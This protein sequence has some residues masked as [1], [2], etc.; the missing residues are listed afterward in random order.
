MSS[1]INYTNSLIKL[2]QLMQYIEYKL[3]SPE[4]IAQQIELRNIEEKRRKVDKILKIVTK[5]I[6][7][8]NGI[9]YGGFALNTILPDELKFYDENE[10]PDFDFFQLDADNLSKVLADKLVKKGFKYTEV[11]HALHEGTYKVFSN[12]ESV[13]DITSVTK[14]EYDVLMGKAIRKSVGYSKKMLIAPLEFLKGAAYLELCLPIGSSFRWTK[15]YKR[16]LLLEQAYPLKQDSDM[17]SMD[18]LLKS[19]GISNQFKSIHK[20]IKKYIKLNNLVYINLEA[21]KYYMNINDDKKKLNILQVLSIDVEQTIK[22]ISSKI[23]AHKFDYEIK[24]FDQYKSF[25]PVK[26]VIYIKGKDDINYEKMI[27]IYDAR[28]HCFA[29]IKKRGTFYCTIY[30]LFYIYYFKQLIHGNRI[31]NESILYELQSI[32]NNDD[33]HSDL[34]KSF[35]N[36]CYGEEHT[37]SAIKKSIWDNKKKIL[38]YRPPEKS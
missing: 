36:E 12:F 30:F 38:F 7:K 33:L 32:L 21:I 28:D 8:H 11:K 31:V 20:E 18:T 35:T 27:S 1:L 25:I 22:D 26:H 29:Y 10:I 34:I 24:T 9:I 3:K 5:F 15:V 4:Q 13:A 19:N 23:R 6:Q 16:L 2:E 14:N 37:M 17:M